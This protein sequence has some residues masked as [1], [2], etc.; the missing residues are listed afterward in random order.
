MPGSII[1]IICCNI[2]I[3]LILKRIKDNKIA[4]LEKIEFN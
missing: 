2:A 3:M 1:T 4:S